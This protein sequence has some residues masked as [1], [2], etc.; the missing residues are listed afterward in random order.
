[1][2]QQALGNGLIGR[3]KMI[4]E[5]PVVRKWVNFNSRLPVL[6]D[7][8]YIKR[9]I[10]DQATEYRIDRWVVCGI[11]LVLCVTAQ[12]NKNQRR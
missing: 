7:L 1:M 4:P 6:L 2:E 12:A 5:L 10:C 9:E 3:Y 8:P 11:L